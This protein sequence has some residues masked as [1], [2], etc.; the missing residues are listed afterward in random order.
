MA[1]P[2]I[3]DWVAEALAPI[4]EVSS[5]AMMGGYTLYCDG[6]VFAIVGHDDLWFKADAVSDA[7]WDAIGAERFAVGEKD[8]KPLTMN[9]RRAPSEVHDE[10]EALCR[11]AE[12]GI[13]AGRRVK[14]KKPK[15]PKE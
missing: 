11:W 2:A 13:A 9:Y 5:R 7:E 1:R 6:I 4:G 12:L 15:A 3:I 14:P 10:A 8:G